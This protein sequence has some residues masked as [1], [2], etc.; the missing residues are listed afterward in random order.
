MRTYKNLLSVFQIIYAKEEIDTLIEQHDILNPASIFGY[1][2]YLAEL[3]C[4]SIYK[5]RILNCSYVKQDEWVKAI[6]DDKSVVLA[7]LPRAVASIKYW[8]DYFAE[9]GKIV[10]KEKVKGFRE[11]DAIYQNLSENEE[12]L[13]EGLSQG[14]Y[15][16][17]RNNVFIDQIKV[18]SDAV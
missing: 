15:E 14:V 1:I 3:N 8:T 10:S 18:M 13:I 16:K 6:N 7:P 5:Q 4:F 9:E 17:H 2:T 11:R 12:I